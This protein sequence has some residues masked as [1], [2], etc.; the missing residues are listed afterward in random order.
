MDALYWVTALCALIVGFVLGV[1]T[2]WFINRV[3][4]SA[5]RA[6]ASLVSNELALTAQ[7]LSG[8]QAQVAEL[9][10]RITDD[11]TR[12]G[13]EQSVLLALAPVTDQLRRVGAQVATLERDRVQQFGALREQLAQAALNDSELLR[14]TSSLAAA[15]V[16]N[17]AR[18]TWGELQLRR[19][20]ESA[21]MLAHVDFIEQLGTATG[22]RPDMVIK[23]PGNKLIIVDSKV[24]LSSYL[25]AQQLSGSTQSES[26]I[27]AKLLMKEHA[28]ALR[29]HVDALAAKSYW[30][31]VEGTPELVVCFLPAESFLADA[32]EADPE[33][34]DHA[35]G[36]NV[37][38]A[39]PAT[40][41]AMLKGL[42]FAWRQEL[43]TANARDLF[44]ASRELYDRLG[45]MGGHVAKLG[46]SLRGSV[47]KYNAFIGTLESRVLPSARRIR[48]LDPGL[49]TEQDP[50][51]ALHSLPPIEATPRALSAAE[52]LGTESLESRR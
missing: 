40:L 2:W 3:P 48:D 27:R 34:L 33:L 42:G 4:L 46:S 5:A 39:S 9:R 29:H 36:K 31:S 1:F 32:L 50:A 7:L 28:K 12:D 16:N 8:A 30:N 15:M 22:L 25:K 6:G 38:L 13:Q 47:E 41:L 23:L 49:G 19:V 24:P 20:V 35:F 10:D 45:T 17:A 44:V 43:L 52:I 11:R 14:T 51:A 26:I 37:A 18:G 21:G